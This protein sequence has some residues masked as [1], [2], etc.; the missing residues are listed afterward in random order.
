MDSLTGNP[1]VA[2]GGGNA[3]LSRLPS[4]Q[5]Q[6]SVQSAASGLPPPV[7][8]SDSPVAATAA[9]GSGGA[10]GSSIFIGA[11][12]ALRGSRDGDPSSAL[13]VDTAGAGIAL[14]SG[15][16]SGSRRGSGQAWAITEGDDEED[17]DNDAA[18]PGQDPSANTLNSQ[19]KQE[20]E[21]DEEP[22]H[23]PA[24]VLVV[25]DSPLCHKIVNKILDTRADF[26][27]ESAFNGLEVR[28]LAPI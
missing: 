13:A 3:P 8:G 9:A 11:T 15:G 25:D 24:R 1:S 18:L 4:F 14:A 27:H 12:Q 5:S 23:R 7:G 22:T 21:E 17:D 6:H 26:E 28:V 16:G 20:E 19:E 2:G 10:A